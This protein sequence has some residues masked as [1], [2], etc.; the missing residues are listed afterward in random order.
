MIVVS[1]TPIV[2]SVSATSGAC[3]IRK[4]TDNT[5]LIIELAIVATSKSFLVKTYHAPMISNIAPR[6][7]NKTVNVVI[8]FNLFLLIRHNLLKLLCMH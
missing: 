8:I 3:K 2:A 6:T 7:T 1:A 4:N 5:R